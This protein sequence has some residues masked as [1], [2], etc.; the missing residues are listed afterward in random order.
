[1]NL[2]WSILKQAIVNRRA[3]AVVDDQRHYRYAD[4]LG[5]AMFVRQY[6]E[7]TTSARHVGIMLPTSGLFPMALLGTWWAGR[8]AVPL[9]Y[10]LARDE[11][12]YVVADSDI[13][14]LITVKPMLDFIGGPEA[15]GPNIKLLLCE[16]MDL[17]GV[18]DLCWPPRPGPDDLAAI[19]YTSG[20][21]G[22]PKGVMLSHG[23]LHADVIASV[24]HVNVVRE[25]I[26]LGVLPQFHSFGFTGLTL[27][28]LYC[29]GKMIYT[30]KFVPR[31]I[32]GLMKKHRP[33]IM[34]AVPSMYGALLSVKDIAPEDVASIRL[35]LSGGEPLPGATYQTY[36]DRL[37]LDI[38]E[39][40]GLTETSP[41]THLS[42]PT[43]L[44]RHAVGTAIDGATTF[45]LDENDRLLPPDSEGEIALAGPMIM[46]GYYKQN[47]LT[48]Q[49]MVDIKLPG[50]DK[51]IRAFRTGDIGKVDED[52][53]LYI[54]GRKKE[55]L[56]IGGENVFP[57]EIEE[58]LNT[59]PAIKDSA[60]IG[61]SDGMRGEVPIAFIELDE[62]A[63]FDEKE[64][65]NICRESLA[66]FKVPREFR[67]LEELPRNPTGKIMR[68]KL[69]AE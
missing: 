28:P 3:V 22:R 37:N 30:A 34:M 16:E 57:R 35:P 7:Q 69:S 19:L 68:R 42:T 54:T 21:S 12:A 43:L 29:G 33:T 62:E 6:I 13:D 14:T 36:N 65:R 41:V 58:V 10:L 59:I 51:T 63:T 1:M 39:G 56:I 5:G 49:V 11:L 23:N 8:A 45:I 47:E 61:K 38:I 31:K 15:L 52:D 32:V 17:T 48:Q 20:T 24:R 44:R 4:L 66:Q 55:M 50:Y 27:M 60:V 53:F 25:D 2:F 26:I 18:P 46:Q 67:I 9:N 40:Y 64:A